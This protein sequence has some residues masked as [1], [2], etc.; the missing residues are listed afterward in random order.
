MIKSH[1][2]APSFFVWASGPHAVAARL[3]RFEGDYFLFE[4]L[5][6]SCDTQR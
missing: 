4:P 6:Y 2:T 1:F 5:R 3:C